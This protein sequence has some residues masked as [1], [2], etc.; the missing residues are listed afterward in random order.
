MKNYSLKDTTLLAILRAY[1]V[2]LFPID[3]Q[4]CEFLKNGS[5]VVRIMGKQQLRGSAV[6]LNAKDMTTKDLLKSDRTVFSK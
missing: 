2:I 3:A 5:V 4:L 6:P 1:W